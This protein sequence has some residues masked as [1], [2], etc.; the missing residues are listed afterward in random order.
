ME[1]LYI[2]DELNIPVAEMMVD[3]K[4]V[5]GS[6]VDVLWDS[7]AMLRDMVLMRMLYTGGIWKVKE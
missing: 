6:K 3:W 7:I 2:A 1:A 4:D 5:E